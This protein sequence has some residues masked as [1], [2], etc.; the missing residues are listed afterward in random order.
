MRTTKAFRI[1]L[2]DLGSP[3][4]LFADHKSLVVASSSEVNFL[5]KLEIAP[6]RE[7]GIPDEE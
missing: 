3:V 7:V 1:C 2:G 5:M 6:R 4:E